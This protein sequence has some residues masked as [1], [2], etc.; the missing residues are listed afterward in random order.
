MYYLSL[1]KFCVVKQDK[2]SRFHLPHCDFVLYVCENKHVIVDKIVFSL[3]FTRLK[4]R[5]EPSRNFEKVFCISFER[6]LQ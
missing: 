4:W 1:Y 2:C 5:K 3:Y 6:L